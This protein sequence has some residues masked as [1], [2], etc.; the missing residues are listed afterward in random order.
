MSRLPVPG[1]DSGIW[2]DV[3]NDYL[4]IEHNTDG[5]LKIRTDGTLAAKANNTDVVHLAGNE[6]ISGTK[7]FTS[8]PIVPSPTAGTQ[9]A[10]KTYVDGVVGAGA[11]DATPSS[12]GIV[13]LAGDLSGTATAPTVPGLAGKANTVHTHAIADVTNLQT[14]LNSKADETIT[15]TGGTSLAGGGDLTA[16]RTL[17][18]LG[19]AA[20]PGNTHYYGTD[21]AGTKGFF[22]IPAGSGEANTASN[23]GV[24]GVGVFKQKTGVNLEFKNI[25]AASSKVT[26]T[27]D[28]PN[29][30]IDI[31]VVEANFTGIPESAVTNLT[32][33]LASKAT[34]T[35]VIHNAIVD[36]KGDIIAATA[37]DTPARLGVGTDGQFLRAD[38]AQSAG[39]IWDTVT[40]SEVGAIPASEKGQPNGVAQLD[41]SGKVTPGQLVS[42]N[43]TKIL[44]YSN[45]GTLAVVSGTHRIYNDSGSTWTIQRVRASVGTAP[46][47]SSIIVDVNKNDTTIFTTQANRPSIAAA[48][49][50]SGSV[51]N[52]DVTTVANG[53]YFTVDIDQVGSTT[54]GSD[55]TV[56]VEVI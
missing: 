54:A 22:P 3:L 38:S 55:L 34:D 40:A 28:G 8:S 7:S 53:E 25:N 44:P 18:L 50:T 47:G 37:N 26:V 33:D 4:A 10:N 12:K 20:T 14:S 19:D 46:A 13:Q 45:T 1:S 24:G 56:Q 29:N 2:G 9:A 36:A 6:T 17:T 11:P 23:V 52:M 35:S 41:G 16:N 30:E 32:T 39:L 5:A 15:I 43:I 42:S 51:T 48:A 21:G 49:N 27:N 31:N